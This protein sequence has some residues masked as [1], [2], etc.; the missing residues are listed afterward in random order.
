MKK[1]R[2][3][4]NSRNR[5]TRKI[6]NYSKTEI[7]YIKLLRIYEITKNNFIEQMDKFEKQMDILE[8]SIF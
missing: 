2:R 7:E 1:T 6:K 3:G 8:K 5:E 4:G